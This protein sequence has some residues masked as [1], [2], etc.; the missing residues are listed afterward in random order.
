MEEYLA[1]LGERTAVLEIQ[2]KSIEQHLQLMTKS[3]QKLQDQMEKVEEDLKEC[4][5]RM[6]G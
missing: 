6:Q 5:K 4:Q 1:K 2:A 3:I